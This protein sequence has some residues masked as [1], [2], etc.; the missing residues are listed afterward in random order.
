MKASQRFL[1]Q[2]AAAVRSTKAAGSQSAK[3]TTKPARKK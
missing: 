2:Q 1:R 3:P